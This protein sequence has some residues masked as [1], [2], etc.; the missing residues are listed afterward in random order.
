ME[1]EIKEVENLTRE[2]RVLE[3][4]PVVV[5]AENKIKLPVVVLPENKGKSVF[6]NSLFERYRFEN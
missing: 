4:L 1:N 5:P 2:V 6:K 3:V